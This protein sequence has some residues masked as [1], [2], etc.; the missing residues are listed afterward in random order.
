MTDLDPVK[1]AEP[2]DGLAAAA[3]SGTMP[4]SNGSVGGRLRTLREER[5][6]SLEDVSIN[7]KFGARQ[8][9]ALEDER[10][11][12]LPQ[13][14]S[15]RG[16]VRNYARLLGTDPEPLLEAIAPRIQTA[17]P[18]SLEQASSLSSP[19]ARSA[20]RSRGWP[21]SNRRRPAPWVIGGLMVIVA[22][23]LL[24]FALMQQGK[25]SFGSA[26]ALLD[27]PAPA[28]QSG[29][30]PLA[31]GLVTDTPL[32]PDTSMASPA[33]PPA[34]PGPVPGST[35]VPA[36]GADAPGVVPPLAAVPPL[37]AMPP[38]AAE[39]K[40][41]AAAV[42]LVVQ[43]REASWVEVRRADGTVAVSQVLPADGHFELEASAAPLR[44]VIGNANG[45]TLSWRGEPV[46][47]SFARR[48][49]VARLTLQ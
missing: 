22:A 19:I 3:K 36:L 26:K 4:A 45:V 29:A 34:M 27:T 16:F 41:P 37:G 28:P 8:I 13:G 46:D 11:T 35:P 12:D 5:G 1:S 38:P 33:L 21:S 48:D 39:S 9:R 6:L 40:P 2:H 18:V 30:E 42:G 20:G 10:W 25:L 49:N 14:M 15:L 43:M 31:P 23:V 17:D 24:G 44:V 47:L 32:P 7:L